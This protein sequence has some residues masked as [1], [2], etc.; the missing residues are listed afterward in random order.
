MGDKRMNE[1]IYINLHTNLSKQQSVTKG[2]MEKDNN[3]DPL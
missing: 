2:N 3:F 1:N